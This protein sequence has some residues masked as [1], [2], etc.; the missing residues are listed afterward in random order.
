MQLVKTNGIEMRIGIFLK[1]MLL[2]GAVPLILV[3]WTM[4][5]VGERK[6]ISQS[7]QHKRCIKREDVQ[8]EISPLLETA[9]HALD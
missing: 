3:A 4:I 7:L 1:L 8:L 2:I 6:E 9:Q 5:C